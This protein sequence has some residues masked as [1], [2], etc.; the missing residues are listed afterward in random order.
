MENRTVHSKNNKALVIGDA[1]LDIWRFGVTE[2]FSREAP[3]PVFLENTEARYSPG[4]AANVAA[5]LAALGVDT[6]LFAV[7]GDDEEGRRLLSL[8]REKGVDT[9]NV[10]VLPQK[11]TM[12]KQRYYNDHCRQIQRVDREDDLQ[13]SPAMEQEILQRLRDLIGACGIVLMTEYRKSFLSEHLVHEIIWLCRQK[14][15]PVFVDPAGND[16]RR[17]HG[18]SMIKPNRWELGQLTGLPVATMEDAAYA[19]SRLCSAADCAYVLATLDK[20]GLMLADRSGALHTETHGAL[21]SSIITCKAVGAGDE[22]LARFTAA[23][24]EGKDVR[25][26][27]ASANRIKGTTVCGR[28]D[29]SGP[30]MTENEAPDKILDDEGMVM[31]ERQGRDGKRLVFTNG[32]FDLLHA[33]HVKCLQEARRMGDL[34][35]VGVNSDDSVRRL[36][37]ED[38][39]VWRLEDRMAVLAGLECVDYIIPFEED[40][41][42]RL[43]KRLLPDVLVKGGDYTMDRMVGAD[44]VLS[45]GG[46]VQIVPYLE[47][48]S[49]T[50]A[51]TRIQGKTEKNEGQE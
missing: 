27:A 42:V 19:A 24:L 45:Y 10:M 47:G 26:A 25:E 36:K 44:I 22:V 46:S 15:V 38:R 32:C 13:I 16:P 49:S 31:L 21:H 1:M 28:K 5:H 2:R 3:V 29:C 39:P 50:T 40:T 11:M 35:V 9:V 4:G 33:G 18:V 51:I 20:D 41:P 8:L 48:R 23:L 37:G 12:L 30:R 17:Y 7:V 6:A 34:L 43:I 14:A